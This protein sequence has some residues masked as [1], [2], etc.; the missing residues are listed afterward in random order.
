MQHN[1]YIYN[2]YFVRSAVSLT[3]HRILQPMP[4]HYSVHINII[5][6]YNEVGVSH[7]L[8]CYHLLPATGSLACRRQ[9]LK[10]SQPVTVGNLA[11]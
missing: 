3:R 9:M 1:I 11:A 4:G 7:S 10:T 8:H 6:T 2:F 5:C